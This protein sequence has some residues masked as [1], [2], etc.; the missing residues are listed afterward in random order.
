LKGNDHAIFKCHSNIRLTD[1]GRTLEMP[2]W[3]SHFQVDNQLWNS[4]WVDHKISEF[5]L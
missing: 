5:L 1:S 4:I 2:L 3:L